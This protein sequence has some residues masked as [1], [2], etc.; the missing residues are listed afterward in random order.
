[1]PLTRV[2]GEEGIESVGIWKCPTAQLEGK[3]ADEIL[4]E[5]RREPLDRVA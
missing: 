1:M 5:N 3:S 2:F 4:L